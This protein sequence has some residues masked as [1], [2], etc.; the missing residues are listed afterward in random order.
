MGNSYVQL[1]LIFTLKLS[2]GPP[3]GMGEP[4]EPTRELLDETE[5]AKL[6]LNF[7]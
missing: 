6:N 4:H 3:L 1:L 5:D 2:D 7:G